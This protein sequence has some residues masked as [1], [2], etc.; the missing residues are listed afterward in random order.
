MFVCSETIIRRDEIER[1]ELLI[2]LFY[3]LFFLHLSISTSPPPVR[4]RVFP[5][6]IFFFLLLP[7]GFLYLLCEFRENESR[8]DGKD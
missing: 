5:V 8:A 6:F 4:M 1:G 3:D 2:L 7:F